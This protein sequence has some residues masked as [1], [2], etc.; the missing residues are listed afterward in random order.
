M[1]GLGVGLDV[2][3][4]GEPLRVLADPPALHVLELHHER[5]LLAVDAR[6]VVDEAVRIRERDRLR[7][8]V[9]EL[10]HRVLGHVPAA[11]DEADLALQRLAAGLEHLLGEVHGAVA[12][13]LG[14]DQRAAPVDALAGQHA[15]ELVPDPLVLPEEVPDLAGPDADVTGRDVRELADVPLELGHEGLAEPHDLGVALPLRVEVGA[16][17]APA[18]GQGRE[19]VLE[20]LLEGQELEEP[21]VDG[22]VEAEPALVRP[23]RAVHLDAVPA[24]DLDLPAVVHPGDP[25][26]DDALGL[27]D[28]LEDLLLAVL[29]V[30]LQ[31]EL[32]GLR[33]LPHG[34][35]ELGLA[36]VLGYDVGHQL[37]DV[38]AHA[39]SFPG[40]GCLIPLRWTAPAASPGPGAAGAFVS[41]PWASSCPIPQGSRIVP[42]R[43]GAGWPA[44]P[45]P[46]GHLGTRVPAAPRR[47]P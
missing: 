13:G 25:E 17:L 21:E 41:V 38:P 27:D 6:G 2:R 18:E 47:S 31:G 10:L 8:V 3:D 24:V 46:I 26:D 37:I 7:P 34:L 36:R 20:H 45:R 11:G 32:D 15:G 4:P 42:G 35:V 19:G 14:P 16:A 22:G 1:V 23:D 28:P 33:D 30:A 29:G 44:S 5:E 12:G 43:Q 40:A 9:E 39:L